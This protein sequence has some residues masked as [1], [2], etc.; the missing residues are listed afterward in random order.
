MESKNIKTNGHDNGQWEKA[1][2]AFQAEC[3]P[4]KKTAVNPFFKS[5]YAPLDEI[6]S[7]VRPVLAKHN[8]GFAQGEIPILGNRVL[9]ENGGTTSA[10]FL[11]AL[12]LVTTIYHSSGEKRDFEYLVPVPD[13]ANAQAMQSLK[14]Y[15]RRGGLTAALGIAP[16]DD[17]DAE[18]AA[19]KHVSQT[20][21]PTRVTRP[22]SW[23]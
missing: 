4:V 6:I 13:G 8:L 11:V 17:D 20:A 23:K 1:F 16:E 19:P 9:A 3:P 2:I 18:A 7:T 21:S 12:K 14:T 10:E 5:R 22:N 15:A